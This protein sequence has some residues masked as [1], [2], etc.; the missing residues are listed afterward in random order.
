MFT[1]LFWKLSAERAVKTFAQTLAGVLVVSGV[2]LFQADW[3]SAVS[4]AAMAAVV[5]ILTSLGSVKVGPED[6]PSVVSGDPAPTPGPAAASPA[7]AP[8]LQAAPAPL[9]VAPVLVTPV[10]VP[11]A[12]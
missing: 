5:S 2:G 4:T 9:P 12:A 7:A 3:R 6:S 1:S 11:D 10:P 8:A